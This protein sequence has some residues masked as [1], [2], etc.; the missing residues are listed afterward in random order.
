MSNS[1]ADELVAKTFREMAAAEKSQ[2]RSRVSNTPNGFIYLIAW[3]NAGLLRLFCRLLAESLPQSEYRTKPHLKDSA[4][5]V[6]ANIE[7][8][9]RRPTTREYLEFLGF[10]QASLE[11]IKGDIRRLRE[12]G[13]IVS[14]PGSVLIS[15]G[16]DLKNWHEAFKQTTISKP[17]TGNYGSLEDA[18]AYRN[19]G[20]TEGESFRRDDRNLGGVRGG[21]IKGNYRSLGEVRSRFDRSKSPSGSSK[22]LYGYDPVDRLT[23]R[24]LT[25]EILIELINKTDWQL[26]RLVVSLEDKLNREHKFYQV[27]KMRVRGF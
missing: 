1:V 11:E 6:M 3:S 9:F 8:G 16:I 24:D 27:E 12:D 14:R 22:F 19:S 23:V 13:F 17:F 10:S 26:R 2:S 21:D 4:R 20:D 5:S 18:R 15:L 25:Y 7:E